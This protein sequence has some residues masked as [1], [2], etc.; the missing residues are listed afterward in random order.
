MKTF[1]EFVAERDLL[2]VDKSKYKL[3]KRA[4]IVGANFLSQF[5]ASPEE[6]ALAKRTYVKPAVEDK[7]RSVI[8]KKAA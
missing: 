1:K 8:V 7:P 4:A 3:L 5:A 6:K 2:E